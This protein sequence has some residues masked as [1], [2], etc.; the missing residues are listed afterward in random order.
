MGKFT[1]ETLINLFQPS[2]PL[3]LSDE[4]LQDL[5]SRPYVHPQVD[6][7]SLVLQFAALNVLFMVVRCEKMN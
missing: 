1:L 7:H 2:L 4:D 5:G 3:S 6:R